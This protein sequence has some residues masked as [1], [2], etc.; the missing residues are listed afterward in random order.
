MQHLL[1]TL[2]VIIFVYDLLAL[3]DSFQKLHM[4][5][6][7]IFYLRF[8]HWYIY[9]SF[10]WIILI[11][12]NYYFLVLHLLIL[13]Q[14][15]HLWHNGYSEHASSKSNIYNNI[16]IYWFFLLPD[17]FQLWRMISYV[18][19]YVGKIIRYIPEVTYYISCM[20]VWKSFLNTLINL[21]HLSDQN[22]MI[23]IIHKYVICLI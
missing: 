10:N 15:L 21:F 11:K 9:M 1:P 5:S 23:T 14:L 16:V 4:I 3:Q 8:S 13:I 22:Q 20:L 17:I 6:K 12:S 18:S 2:N 19:F 7:V